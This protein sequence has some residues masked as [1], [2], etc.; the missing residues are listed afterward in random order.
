MF[1]FKLI[2]TEWVKWVHC[3]KFHLSIIFPKCLIYFIAANQMLICS[4]HRA[5]KHGPSP[6]R[7]SR[8]VQNSKCSDMQ[9]IYI[10]IH[11]CTYVWVNVRACQTCYGTAA[12]SPENNKY[13]HDSDLLLVGCTCCMSFVSMSAS[14]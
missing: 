7:K 3:K 8:H 2:H 1:L 12:H 6:S 9:I 5:H 10:H 13:A 14:G 11:I 4:I